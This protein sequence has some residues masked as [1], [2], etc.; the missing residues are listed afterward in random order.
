MVEPVVKKML[1]SAAGQSDGADAMRRLAHRGDM[2]GAVLKAIGDCVYEWDI[3]SDQIYWSEDAAKVLD[4]ADADT[5]ANGRS[6]RSLLLSTAV[7]SRDEVIFSGTLQD[8]GTGVPYRIRYALDG[9]HL[10]ARDD[11]WI[12]DTGCFYRNS[13]GQPVRAHGIMR[14]INERRSLEE[15]LDSLARFDALTG[16]YNRNH[17]TSLLDD[18]FTALPNGG[19]P[20]GFLLIAIEHFDLVNSVY[21]Y[22]AGDAVMV[23]VANRLKTNLRSVDA[24]GRFS[25]AR[26]AIVLEDCD[27]RSLLVAAHRIINLFRD[28]VVET[29]AGPIAVSLA[30]G[31]VLLPD[32]ASTPKQTFANAMT[33]LSEA[34]RERD[35]AV[36]VFHHDP[37]RDRSHRN[38]IL[39]AERILHALKNGQIHLVFQPVVEADSKNIAFHEALVRLEEESGTVMAAGDFVSVAQSLGLIRLV[40]HHALDLALETLIAHREA[41]L[42]LN[43]SNETACDPEWISKLAVAANANPDITSRLIVE[44][45]ESHIVESLSESRRFIQ[46]LHDLGFQVALDDF[47]AGFTSFRNLKELDFDIIKVDGYFARGLEHSPENRSFIN[48]LVGLAGLF[49]ARTVVEWIEDDL[50]AAE[51]LKGGVDYLQGYRFGKPERHPDWANL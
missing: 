9:N 17:I 11:I 6:F 33:A 36:V 15:R 51:M 47:G 5:L 32:H 7:T 34:R 20:A 46:T 48:A 1:E 13:E 50:S 18:I 21:G 22:E 8:D 4:V 24:I 42:S 49:N 40:D 29:S 10:H 28:E 26:L 19:D 39:L 23:E 45:T 37:E 2:A 35:S 12:E 14:V 25:G 16:L 38:S 44:I 43:V 30:L 31:G 3:A 27:E 41:R